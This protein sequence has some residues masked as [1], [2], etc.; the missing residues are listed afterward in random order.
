MILTGGTMWRHLPDLPMEITGVHCY[1]ADDPLSGVGVG[2][3][4][5]SEHMEML[6][7]KQRG[8]TRRPESSPAASKSN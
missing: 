8:W 1:V 4:L 5:K 3:G 6:V 2:T 7:T